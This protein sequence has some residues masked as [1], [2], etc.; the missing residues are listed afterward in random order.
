MREKGDDGRGA[1][2]S[3]R[4]GERR[5]ASD[6]PE[7]RA[8]DGAV[9]SRIE[10]ARVESNSQGQTAKSRI[11]SATPTPDTPNPTPST[12]QQYRVA[13][14]GAGLMRRPPTAMR[15][16]LRAHGHII[17]HHVPHQR[18]V[19]PTSSNIGRHQHG[20]V[21]RAEAVE[22][23]ES[24]ALLH[25]R[26][27][28]ARR[29]ACVRVCV[30]VCVCARFSVSIAVK[31]C[32]EVRRGG[33]GGSFLDFTGQRNAESGVWRV[34]VVCVCVWCVVCVGCVTGRV[35]LSV[36][37]V[38]LTR[39]EYRGGQARRPHAAARRYC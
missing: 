20:A 37:R 16:H 34:C 27:Q 6:T 39:A 12:C 31:R 8:A 35:L 13:R 22:V 15:V 5:E 1:G 2:R 33:G 14:V 3:E 21:E 36:S 23:A 32:G 19:E 38:I 10:Q 25:R 28:R 24:R 17:V 18:N 29:N 7:S 11:K 30:C 9:P 26:V 4:R